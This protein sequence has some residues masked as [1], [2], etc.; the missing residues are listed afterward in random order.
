MRLCSLLVALLVLVSKVVIAFPDEASSRDNL[1][2]VKEI[3]IGFPH[4]LDNPDKL[5]PTKLLR[6]S[7]AASGTSFQLKNAPIEM[8]Q[9]RN[10][11]E[12]ALGNNVDVFW[13]MT[14]IEREKTLRPIRIP[15]DKGLYGWRLLLVRED[16]TSIDKVTKLSDFKKLIFLQG[17]DWPDTEILKSNNLKVLTSEKYQYLFSMMQKGRADILPRSV[18]EVS[19]ERSAFN[20]QLK[21]HP[22]VSIYYPAALYFFVRKENE[23]LAR[24]I[25]TGLNKLIDSG[26]FE[27]LFQE[28]FGDDIQD[29][30]SANRAIIT[31]TNPYLP[32]DTP[33]HRSELWHFN[34]E[35]KKTK[36]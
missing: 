26:E 24:Q 17:H 28:E 27:R 23:A 13:T 33:F 11:R 3:I 7:L 12:I 10:L 21:I 36:R 18:L 2:N 6:A 30:I 5:Y 29:A 20:H 19:D 14:S 15:I 25:E 8:S 16:D 31:L 35:D 32:A 1:E 9:D 4:Q 34:Q 22:S